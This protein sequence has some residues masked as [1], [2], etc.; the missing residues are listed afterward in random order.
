MIL[1]HINT[2]KDDFKKCH[3]TNDGC[4]VSA[5]LSGIVHVLNILF[6]CDLQNEN[7]IGLVKIAVL[8]CINSSLECRG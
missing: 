7:N 1:P 6:L 5:L 2:F 3:L 4:A 8:Q